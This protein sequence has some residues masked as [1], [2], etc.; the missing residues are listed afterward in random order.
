LDREI[1]TFLAWQAEDIV[2]AP[3]ATR[4]A[5]RL[6]SWG[7]MPAW[8]RQRAQLAWGA[9][10]GLLVGLLAAAALVSGM[11]PPA[12]NNLGSR[13]YEAV[14]LRLVADGANIDVIVVAV[15]A[16]GS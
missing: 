7:R 5:L 3:S 11:I 8:S 4:V 9:L 12:P 15:N 6:G 10:A 14:F 1:R 2:G 16:N 13:S